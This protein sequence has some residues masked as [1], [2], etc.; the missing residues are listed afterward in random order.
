MK[1]RISTCRSRAYYVSAGQKFGAQKN[2]W[3]KQ[4]LNEKDLLKK[5]GQKF[6]GK[7]IVGQKNCGQKIFGSTKFL[8]KKWVNIIFGKKDGS[9]QL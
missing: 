2:S 7:Q 1:Q 4:Y 3:P 8:A 6:W 9:K 5:N